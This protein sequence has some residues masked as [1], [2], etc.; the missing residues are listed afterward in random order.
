MKLTPGVVAAWPGGNVTIVGS[1]PVWSDG[2]DATYTQ[3]GVDWVTGNTFSEAYAPLI[4]TPIF[5][6][7]SA[8]VTAQIER[9]AGDDPLGA[10][11][12]YGKLLFYI[13]QG[14]SRPYFYD[15]SRVI[16]PTLGVSTVSFALSAGGHDLSEVFNAPVTLNVSVIGSLYGMWFRVIDAYVTV[17]L[18][19]T[20]PL[21]IRQRADGLGANSAPSLR[22][23]DTQQTTNRLNGTY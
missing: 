7:T 15:V 17:T 11:D 19:T 4:G 16:A 5:G 6:V 21:Q 10:V 18:G 22:R 20:P 1:G 14:E 9:N 2:S 23:P 8:V 3:L 12:G 13:A